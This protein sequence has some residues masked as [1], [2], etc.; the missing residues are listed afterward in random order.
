M[1]TF[2]ERF[3]ARRKELGY[4]ME[5]IAEKTG[6]SRSSLYRFEQ[7]S[8]LE[9]PVKSVVEIANVLRCSPSYLLGSEFRKDSE[10]FVVNADSEEYKILSLYR[11]ADE[12]T[13][14]MIKRLLAYTE[15]Y[16]AISAINPTFKDL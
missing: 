10:S 14:R 4:T 7:K 3:R 6:L 16:K 15:S 12:D 1:Q 2:G 5:Y 13:K 11:L 8:P 9:I